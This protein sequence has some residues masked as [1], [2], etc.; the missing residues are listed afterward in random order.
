M[1]SIKP[2]RDTKKDHLLTPDNSLVIFID[3]QP[4]QVNSINS[5]NKNLMMRNVVSLAKIA[6]LYSV[7]MVLS[8]VNV[9]TGRNADTVSPL[10]KELSDLPSIDRTSINAWEDREFLGAVE[11]SGRKKLIIAAL[12]TEACLSFPTLDALQAGYDVY[13]PV[14]A[15]GGTSVLA[16]STAL[17]RMEQAGARPVTLPQLLCEYQR[18]WDRVET[19][20][21]FV[22]LLTE[23]NAF[24]IH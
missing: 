23:V 7:P 8:T 11:T 3:Y 12:W 13:L 10:K 15:V 17:A 22:D 5:S 14:D 6:K 20:A 19:V 2:V 9:S 4:T 21:G 18:D 24:P 1:T 16:H